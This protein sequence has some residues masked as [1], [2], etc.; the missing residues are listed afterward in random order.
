[1]TLNSPVFFI[2][3]LYTI[4]IFPLYERTSDFSLKEISVCHFYP[5]RFQNKIPCN[6]A[7]SFHG[8]SN[9][10]HGYWDVLFVRHERHVN[11]DI[12]KD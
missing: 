10:N 11:A 1:M 8:S 3:F 2:L 9:V 12:N 6:E 4:I 7:D 5:L